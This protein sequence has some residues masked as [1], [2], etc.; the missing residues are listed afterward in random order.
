MALRPDLGNDL[1]EFHMGRNQNLQGN[2]VGSAP[3]IF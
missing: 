2:L 1:V 3:G